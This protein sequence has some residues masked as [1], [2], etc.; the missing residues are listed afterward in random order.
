MA[1]FDRRHPPDA[2]GVPVGLIGDSGCNTCDL[3][4]TMEAEGIRVGSGG[5]LCTKPWKPSRRATPMP[6]LT[7]AP[8]RPPPDRQRNH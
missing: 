8:G 2:D 4:T 1:A 6:K 3:H 7:A 5:H